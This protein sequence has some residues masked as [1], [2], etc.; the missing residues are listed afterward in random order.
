MLGS[1][2]LANSDEE[3][4]VPALTELM[5]YWGRWASKQTVTEQHIKCCDK[6]KP[7][8]VGST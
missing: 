1:R 4:K 8:C 5:L 6:E 3:D 2:D 7:V